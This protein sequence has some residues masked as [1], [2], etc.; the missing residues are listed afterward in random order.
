[1]N[2]RKPDVLV[3]NRA[4]IPIHVV[5]WKKAMSLIYQESAKALDL[6]L[7]SYEYK[8]WLEFSKTPFLA[9]LPKVSSIHYEVAVPEII[10]LKY[11]DKLPRR[12]VKYSRQTLFEL[13]GGV[14]FWCNT[15]FDRKDLTVDH[16]V[17][18]SKG[19][20]TSWENTVPSCKACNFKKGDKLIS[21][22]GWKMKITPKK[23]RWIS[24][25]SHVSKN[26]HRKSWSNFMDRT[27]LVDLGD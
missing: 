25:L 14:C 3:L 22:L 18:V 9:D 7:V 23:P 27:A 6:D 26:I 17:P 1:M 21:E 12:D 13:Y 15:K 19:G 5:D 10:V 20:K 11:Y 8:D 4:W 16:V 2:K 24:P